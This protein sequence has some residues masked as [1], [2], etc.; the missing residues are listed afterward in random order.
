MIK[1]KERLSVV[2]GSIIESADA[3]KAEEPS[4]VTQGELIAYTEVL[5]IIRLA[6]TGEDMAEIGLDFIP[7]AK[8]L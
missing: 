8:Y 4:E 3:V 7:E 2:V 1:E 5:D 6:F